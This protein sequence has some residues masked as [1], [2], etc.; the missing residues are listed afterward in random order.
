MLRA[1]ISV[2]CRTSTREDLIEELIGEVQDEFDQEQAQLTS[3]GNN[4]YVV[5][6]D[7]II[8]YLNEQL[9]LELSNEFANTI[10]GLVLHELG[11]IPQ[12]GDEVTVDNIRFKVRS[13]GR[14][15]HEIL[16]TLPSSK[17]T[18]HNTEVA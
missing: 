15:V 14:A 7:V 9:N 17:P 3:L 12:V 6:G 11:R 1:V 16:M 5:R 4:Q 10:G 2:R 18:P 13:A 8:T